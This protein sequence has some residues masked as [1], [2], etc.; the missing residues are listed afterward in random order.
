[1]ENIKVIAIIVNATGLLM[2]II[3]VVMLFYARDKAL[4]PIGAWVRLTPS[5]G[6]WSQ[7]T[8][9]VARQ[10]VNELAKQ[11]DRIINETNR[12]NE[13]LYKQSSKWLII[14]ILGFGLQFASTLLGLAL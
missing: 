4:K 11:I 8:V 14:I 13:R 2:D 9:E 10:E 3:G 1:M 7:T 5:L 12:R 6:S